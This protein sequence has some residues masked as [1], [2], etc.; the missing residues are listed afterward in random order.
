MNSTSVAVIG[1]SA[2]E[3]NVLKG[4]FDLTS[5]RPTSFAPFDPDM[6]EEPGLFLVDA[7]SKEFVNETLSVVVTHPVPVVLVGDSNCGTPYPFVKR[8]IK[9][10]QLLKL[11]E[12]SVAPAAPSQP[13]AREIDSALVVDDSLPVR[14][15]MELKLAPYSIGVD[16]AES[17]EKAIALAA[18]KHYT[19]VFLDVMLP[20]VDGY[21]VCKAIKKKKHEG[22]PTAVVML[23]G[24]TS[25]F[26]KIRGTMAGCDAYLTKPVDEERLLEVILKFIPRRERADAAFDATQST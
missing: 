13:R 6:G 17:G 21:Q 25:P 23:T 10:V 4:I 18:E 22:K 15:F 2:Q 9:W 7:S 5:R 24:K 12:N 8:P 16:F 1:F 11:L 3:R 26:D 14:K 19:C 20:G